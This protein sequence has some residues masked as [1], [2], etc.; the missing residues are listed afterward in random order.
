MKLYKWIWNYLKEEI[1]SRPESKVWVRHVT[2]VAHS[3]R[4]ILCVG[5]ASIKLNF[6]Y[7]SFIIQKLT[8][9]KLIIDFNKLATN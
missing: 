5:K 7:E 6:F 4:L 9:Q 1:L 3:T 8:V 2:T